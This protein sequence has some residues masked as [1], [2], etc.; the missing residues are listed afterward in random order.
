MP[1]MDSMNFTIIPSLGL[2]FAVERSNV[3]WKLRQS[4]D[5]RHGGRSCRDQR[6]AAAGFQTGPRGGPRIY[7]MLF[8]ITQE[9]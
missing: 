3:G 8:P 5:V 4:I 1:S 2:M 7:A 6:Y 9:S